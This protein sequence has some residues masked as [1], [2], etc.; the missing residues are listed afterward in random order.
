MVNDP[1]SVIIVPFI[2]VAI[3]PPTRSPKF[4]SIA[5]EFASGLALDPVVG[6]WLSKTRWK[7]TSKPGAQS[8]GHTFHVTIHFQTS[9]RAKRSGIRLQNV[10]TRED[11]A[12]LER[13]IHIV[14]RI[15]ARGHEANHLPRMQ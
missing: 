15:H 7:G 8:D 4:R 11:V 10:R 12:N 2:V 13:A 14:H 9:F 6:G 1:S 5:R 3:S